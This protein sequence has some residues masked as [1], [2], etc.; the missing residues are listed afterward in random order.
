MTGADDTEWVDCPDCDDTCP[1]CGHE[2]E[3]IEAPDPSNRHRCMMAKCR[4]DW[5]YVHTDTENNE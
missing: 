2:G 1:N 4:V 5:Y 3:P